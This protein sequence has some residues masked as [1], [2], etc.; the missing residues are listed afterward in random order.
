VSVKIV[1]AEDHHVVRKGLCALIQQ[2]EGFV[3]VGEADTCRVA[4]RL[5]RELKPD[6]VIMDVT[7]PEL[8]GVEAARQIRRDASRT[9]ILALSMHEDPLLVTDMLRAGASG[10]LLKTCIV[11]DL[12][13]AVETVMMGHTYLSPKIAGVVASV[14]AHPEIGA[15]P[16][17]CLTP[18][19]RQVLQLLAEGL[20]TKQAAL[21]LGRSVKTVEMHRRNLMDKLGL[22]GIADLTKLALR[23]GLIS[24]GE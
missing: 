23:A 14:L 13:R 6:V 9:K 18:V 8:N 24:L 21:R 10:Y 5:A 4:V 7:M 11:S 15:S 1:V 16:V 20:T 2:Q 12:V 17:S 22:K 3:V 19:Q